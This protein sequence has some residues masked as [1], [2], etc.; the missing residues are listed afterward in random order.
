MMVAQEF[1]EFE[2]FVELKDPW[3]PKEQDGVES[4]WMAPSNSSSG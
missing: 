2:K 3:K 4:L 1:E